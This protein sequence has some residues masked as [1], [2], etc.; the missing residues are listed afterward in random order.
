ME[1]EVICLLRTTNG[2]LPF[3]KE[4]AEENVWKTS[5]QKRT[6]IFVNNFFIEAWD[7]N[8]FILIIF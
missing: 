2:L 8:K 5:V 7:S 4:A 6:F 3:E 1:G